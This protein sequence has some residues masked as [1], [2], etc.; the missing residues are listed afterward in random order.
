VHCLA[1]HQYVI[2]LQVP[3][4]HHLNEDSYITIQLYRMPVTINIKQYYVDSLQ[5]G[6]TKYQTEPQ[7]LLEG[8]LTLALVYYL[9]HPTKA[10]VQHHHKVELI[11][12]KN[13]FNQALLLVAEL[14]F[15]HEILFHHFETFPLCVVN[16]LHI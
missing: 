5:N 8:A 2:L 16:A 9:H 4:N 12:R 10:L 3:C 1:L 14:Q 6:L 7:S 13:K 11:R 15:T